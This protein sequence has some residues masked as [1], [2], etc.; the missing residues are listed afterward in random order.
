MGITMKFV[1]PPTARE[2]EAVRARAKAKATK[3]A[4]RLADAAKKAVAHAEASAKSEATAH[5]A[6]YPV[7]P[8]GLG[9]RFRAANLVWREWASGATH[10]EAIATGFEVPD[11]KGFAEIKVCVDE[12]LAFH[13]EHGQ[14]FAKFIVYEGDKRIGS[15][16]FD[17]DVTATD[18]PYLFAKLK[19]GG[20]DGYVAYNDPDTG[21][22]SLDDYSPVAL[23]IPA[24]GDEP[25]S[26]ALHGF[27]AASPIEYLRFEASEKMPD[28]FA[29]MWHA[30][31]ERYRTILASCKPRN[32]LVY[33]VH[34][35]TEG[36]MAVYEIRGEFPYTFAKIG[37]TVASDGEG[38]GFVATCHGRFFDDTPSAETL[39]FISA[40]LA[41]TGRWLVL[42]P[43]QYDFGPPEIHALMS[44]ATLESETL[45]ANI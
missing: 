23:P 15:G 25:F 32:F 24:F 12:T 5:D 45:V 7:S 28:G 44:G 16:F 40:R 27:D 22:L 36:P 11:P 30:E 35:E 34:D 21:S 19:S 14:R 9:K 4:Q 31:R 2:K 3:E 8:F 1:R 42:V 38:G 37:E 26:L 6:Q 43:N 13:A 39:A 10:V 29:A 18:I 20:R 41:S 17:A 33:D